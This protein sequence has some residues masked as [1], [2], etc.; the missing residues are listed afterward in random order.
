MI[1]QL[2][3]NTDLQAPARARLRPEEE[4]LECTCK[5]SWFE[6]ITV[7][8]KSKHHFVIPGQKVPGAVNAPGPFVLLRCIGCGEVY[9]PQLAGI[10][11]QV[12]DAYD[13]V[14][15][16]L[17]PPEVPTQPDAPATDEEKSQSK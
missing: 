17:R 3:T 14:M 8:R 9:E 2:N 5:V 4:Y 7:S 10:T 15:T 13:K 16:E 6:E 1:N 11:P 12:R